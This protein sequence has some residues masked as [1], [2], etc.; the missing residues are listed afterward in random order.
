MSGTGTNWTEYRSPWARG[1][2]RRMGGQMLAL[3][4]ILAVAGALFWMLTSTA[5]AGKSFVTHPVILFL[6]LMLFA[7]V[8]FFGWQFHVDLRIARLIPARDGYLCPSC[9]SVLPSDDDAGTCAR[10]GKPYSGDRL[11]AHW[12]Q[13]ALAP[14]SARSWPAAPDREPATASGS[15]MTRRQQIVTWLSLGLLLVAWPTVVSWLRGSSLAAA[16]IESV[17]M[18]AIGVCW[19]LGLNVLMFVYQSRRGDSRHCARCD[20]MQPPQGEAP[21][22]CPECRAAWLEP[23]GT[24]RG[25]RR[26]VPWSSL[27]A[28]GL[29]LVWIGMSL[30]APTTGFSLNKSLLRLVPNAALIHDAARDAGARQDAWDELAGRTLSAEQELE[31]AR[32]LLDLRARKCYLGEAAGTW[33]FNRIQAGVLPEDVV[34]RFFGEALRIW[35]EAPER[36]RVGEAL[37]VAIGSEHCLSTLPVGIYEYLYIDGFA[38]GEPA[39]RADCRDRSIY[40]NLL[41]DPRYRVTATFVPKK[42]G[43]LVIRLRAWLAVGPGLSRD[44]AVWRPDGTPRL[45]SSVVRVE[46]FDITRTI[47]VRDASRE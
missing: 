39:S 26:P 14:L 1:M 5:P 44:T 22:A 41:D 15:G 17:P 12:E 9:R 42:P 43:P 16:T 40:A 7:L 23:G 33:F 34:Q 29:L 47:E 46:A 19:G 31:L 27:I 20:Y 4:V 30:L 45:P 10:C 37:Q 24:V 21:S 36:A 8:C 35:I 3:T 13:Y 38:F 32:G 6:G 18:I 2:R 11:R 28:C 25:E